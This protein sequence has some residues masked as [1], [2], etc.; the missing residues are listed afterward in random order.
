ML[1]FAAASTLVTEVLLLVLGM[2]GT[3]KP[4]F[5]DW[6]EVMLVMALFMP[7][8]AGLAVLRW[9]PDKSD[10]Q[11]WPRKPIVSGLLYGLITPTFL[12]LS[13]VLTS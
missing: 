3:L 5:D 6:V 8:I 12:V 9:P 2:T 11:K 10:F 7:F 1:I 13:N 4:P